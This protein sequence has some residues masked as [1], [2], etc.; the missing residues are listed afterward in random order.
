MGKYKTAADGIFVC[1][2]FRCLEKVDWEDMEEIEAISPPSGRC[3]F[4]KDY[5]RQ[6]GTMIK[7]KSEK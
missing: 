6:A 2:S 5:F 1:P 4:C 7:K 3:Y